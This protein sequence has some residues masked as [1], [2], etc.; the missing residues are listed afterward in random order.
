MKRNDSTA[1]PTGEPDTSPLRYYRVGYY[2]MD[3][4]IRMQTQRKAD[5]S[6]VLLAY[7]ETVGAHPKREAF[8]AG[9]G[10]VARRIGSDPRTVRRSMQALIREGVLIV[11]REA[12]RTRP[13]VVKLQKDPR[14]WGAYAPPYLD[15]PVTGEVWWNPRHKPTEVGSD[16]PHPSDESVGTDCPH[17][18]DPAAVTVGTDCPPAGGNLTP[19]RSKEIGR[20][21]AEPRP[22]LGP[23][24]TD[25]PH[26]SRLDS[27]ARTCREQQDVADT[28]H[29][30][31][32]DALA[33]VGSNHD[34]LL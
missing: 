16:S 29:R 34:W 4:I 25:T 7:H 28:V 32:G 33:A 27:N 14:R 8:E 2:L 19:I 1:W 23:G 15:H 22:A 31:S 18:A 11:V 13:R 20:A 3:S 21:G 9:N 26:R 5:L 30:D 6:I 17:R 12:T 24:A 10:Y